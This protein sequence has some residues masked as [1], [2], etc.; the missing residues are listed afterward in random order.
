MDIN[1]FIKPTTRVY[2]KQVLE[3][4]SIPAI[5]KNGT[6]FFTDLDVYENGRVA[7]WNF[8]DFEHF[9]ND[10]NRGWVSVSIPD[11][12]RISIHGL[13]DWTIGNGNWIFDKDTFIYYVQ[14]LIKELNP[15]LENLFQYS[16]KTINGVSIGENGNGTVFKELKKYPNDIF[17]EKLEGQSVNLFYKESQGYYLIKV[18]VF[19]DNTLQLSRLE[20]PIDLT[21]SEFEKL[22]KE[23][24]IL[25]EIPV[26]SKVLI[27][28]LGNFEIVKNE[29]HTT[30]EEKVLE[31]RDILR[32]LNGQPSTIVIC[33]EA[34]RNYIENPT[35]A[36]RE[37]LKN[38]YEKVPDH[39]KMYVG[40]MDTKDTEVR[41]IIYGDQEIESWSHYQVAKSQ[42]KTLPTITV[43][44][45]KD[46]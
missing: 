24:I 46:E 43:I 26:H 5:I 1:K 7:C 19:A 22:V 12:E 33:R 40:D 30:I 13:G 44:R 35:I 39:Q 28:G 4:Y 15:K 29:F 42:G 25:T 45:P 38:S 8:E 18:N 27:Y 37:K 3:G 41:M 14:Q 10:V 23:K 9:K 17:P 20:T 36:N 16:K 21:I 31:I 34:Y 11:N 2:R 32:D 6:H